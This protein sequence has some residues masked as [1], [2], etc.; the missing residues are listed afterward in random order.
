MAEESSSTSH[1]SSAITTTEEMQTTAGYTAALWSSS[2]DRIY[3]SL[4]VVIGIIG[5]AGNALIIYAMVASKQHRKQLLIFNQNALDLYTCV[6]LFITYL[7]KFSYMSLAGSLDYW[8]CTLILSDTF[9]WFGKTGSVLNLAIITVD[10][11]LK[12]WSKKTISN[13]TIYSAMAFAWIGSVAYNLAA[14]FSTTAVVNGRCLPYAIFRNQTA[15]LFFVFWNAISFYVVVIFIFVFCYGRILIVIRRQAKVMASHNSSQSAATQNLSNQLQNNVIKTM[16]FVSAF[17]AVMWLPNYVVLLLYYSLFPSCARLLASTNPE[18]CQ[19][20]YNQSVLTGDGK[21][22]NQKI[23]IYPQS[24]RINQRCE[25]S[26][27]EETTLV[28][29]WLLV[30]GCGHGFETTITGLK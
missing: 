18:L 24:K 29:V 15:K 6:F 23:R 30:S 11:Y 20:I 4:L 9:I 28:L 7:V 2:D 19:S 21:S 14:V 13:W 12:V 8:F 5:T 3:F 17:Y 10:R 1:L 26:R 25:I 16:I 22:P 27:P